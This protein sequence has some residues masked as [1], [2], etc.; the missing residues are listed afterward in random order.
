MSS[1]IEIPVVCVENTQLIIA[2]LERRIAAWQTQLSK[3][4]NATWIQTTYTLYIS[5]A[6]K[7]L[8]QFRQTLINQTTK[9]RVS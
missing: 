6:Q 4:N 2:D 8:T 1:R 3:P 9:T 7:Q 5:A